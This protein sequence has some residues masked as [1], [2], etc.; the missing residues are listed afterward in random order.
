MSRAN[1]VVKY[2]DNAHNAARYSSVSTIKVFIFDIGVADMGRTAVQMREVCVS[3]AKD[4][5]S[6]LMHEW[7]RTKKQNSLVY[8]A[9]HGLH[10]SHVRPSHKSLAALSDH[11]RLEYNDV[12]SFAQSEWTCTLVSMLFLLVHWSVSCRQKAAKEQCAN[13]FKDLMI[14][15][16]GPRLPD[17]LWDSLAWVLAEGAQEGLVCDSAPDPE[18]PVCQHLLDIQVAWQRQGVE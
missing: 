8:L 13:V 6:W 9:S 5:K 15:V 7:W 12:E 1:F 14:L 16:F 11:H 3:L 10:S 17:E 18:T 4:P 2:F